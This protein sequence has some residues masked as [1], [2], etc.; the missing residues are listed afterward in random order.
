MAYGVSG[1]PVLGHGTGDEQPVRREF[2]AKPGSLVRRSTFAAC[3][4]QT[5]GANKSIFISTEYKIVL[6]N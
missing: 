4:L 2:S 6:S 1:A 3:E 5:K